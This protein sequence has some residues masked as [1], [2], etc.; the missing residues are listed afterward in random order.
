MEGKV[1]VDSIVSLG[2]TIFK[3]Y[4]SFYLWYPWTAAQN[5]QQSTGT[6]GPKWLYKQIIATGTDKSNISRFYDG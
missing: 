1:V 5:R 2:L 6:G 4:N 3:Y